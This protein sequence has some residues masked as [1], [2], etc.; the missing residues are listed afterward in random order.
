MNRRERFFFI[1]LAPL[2]SA[3]LFLACSDDE[4]G[5][6]FTDTLDASEDS[7]SSLPEAATPNDD[8]G[9]AGVPD[10]HVPVDASDE[11]VVCTAKPC[12]TQLVGG[13]N[14]FCALLDD[15]TVRCWGYAYRALGI[16]DAGGSSEPA[17][18]S[19]MSMGLSGV[20][21]IS[22]GDLTTCARLTDG[23]VTCWGSNSANEL[24]LDPPQS[25][26]N[27]HGPALVTAGGGVLDGVSRVDVGTLGVVFVQKDSGEL[28][29]WGDNAEDVLGRRGEGPTYLGPG[30]VTDLAKEKIRRAGGGSVRQ[31]SGAGYAITDDG[32]LFT[33]GTSKQAVS[34][35]GPVPVAV[36]GFEN[37]SSVSGIR[38]NLCAVED[39]RLYCWGL[40]GVIACSGSTD[41]I[42]SPLEIRT[43]GEAPVQ[44]VSVNYGS[45]CVRLT[46]GTVECCGSDQ[47]GQLGTGEADAGPS[48]KSPLLTKATAFTG[49]AVRVV[50]SNGATCV[51]VQDG[52][53][54][55]WGSNQ[56][57]EL[58]QGTRDKERHPVPAT[59]EFD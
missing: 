37:V 6:A 30:P 19:P 28:W 5:R 14:H 16:F 13:S 45:T 34:Y 26:Y 22:A 52:S 39:G 49:H 18:P 9:D 38:D 41:S 56:Y 44:Q 11:P 35:P 20:T 53:V 46:D 32:R 23:T 8:A 33:W 43:R 50:A 47:Y 29:S 1:A 4:S 54:Q 12:V 25:D 36:A 51:L 42:M 57:G 40:S 10:V 55:C 7:Q 59:V 31:Q 3:S 48:A 58:G 2:A 15:K 17:Q 21:Q 27:A 24:G